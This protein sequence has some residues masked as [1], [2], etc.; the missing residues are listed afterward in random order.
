[1]H[2]VSDRAGLWH[3]AISLDPMELSAS[4]YSVGA[5]EEVTYTAEYPARAFPCQRFDAPL[6]S[7]ST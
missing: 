5:P 7:S 2:G 3:L 4:P 1:V 6:A